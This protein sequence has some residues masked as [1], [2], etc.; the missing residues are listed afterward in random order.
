MVYFDRHCEERS[1]E[2]IQGRVMVALD[3]FVAALLAMTG[4]KSRS[5]RVG[6]EQLLGGEQR[7][8]ARA[9]VGHDDLLLDARGREAVARRAVGLER[10]HHALLDLDRMV[11]R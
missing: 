11:E 8:D 3:C 2:A 10:E 4:W 5:I 9:L 7:D 1:D 6:D